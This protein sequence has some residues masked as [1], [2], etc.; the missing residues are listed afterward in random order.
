VA[1]TTKDTFT[2]T[3][4]KYNVEVTIHHCDALEMSNVVQKDQY[5]KRAVTSSLC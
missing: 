4:A 1:E 5:G 3:M 2:I